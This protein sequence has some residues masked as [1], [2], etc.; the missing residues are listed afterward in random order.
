MREEAKFEYVVSIDPAFNNPDVQMIFVHSFSP[1]LEKWSCTL[2][3][4]LA[5]KWEFFH[6]YKILSLWQ[7]LTLFEP[8]V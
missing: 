7:N 3:K 5:G 1:F 4:Y 6:S 2:S 8:Q